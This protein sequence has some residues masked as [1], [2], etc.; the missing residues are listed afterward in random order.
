VLVLKP[1]DTLEYRAVTLGTRID[2][3]RVVQDGLR[4]ADVIVVNGLQHVTAGAKVL[5]T[6]VTMTAGESGL[7]QVAVPEDKALLV[8]TESS[9]AVVAHP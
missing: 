6:R 2:G 1:D 5:A 3:L 7:A 4:R 9:A 8:R